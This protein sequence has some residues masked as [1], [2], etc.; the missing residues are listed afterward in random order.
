[1]EIKEIL[2]ILLDFAIMFVMIFGVIVLDPLYL[3]KKE[4]PGIPNLN[5]NDSILYHL[6]R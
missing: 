3:P 2:I 6:P 4:K 5:E 1:M